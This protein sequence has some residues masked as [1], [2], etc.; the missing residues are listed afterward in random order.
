MRKRRYS[1]VIQSHHISYDPEVTVR[2]FKG[3]HYVLTLLGRRKRISA[4]LLAALEDFAQSNWLK[5]E[6]LK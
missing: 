5:A 2:V 6:N 4:G 1:T 3:E